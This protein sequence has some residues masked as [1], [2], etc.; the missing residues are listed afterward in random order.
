MIRLQV[1]HPVLIS[2][3]ECFSP[4]PSPSRRKVMGGGVA[5]VSRG[6][7]LG[8]Q[9]TRQSCEYVPYI[10][11]LLFFLHSQPNGAW[12]PC[13]RAP[14]HLPTQRAGGQ[15]DF[16]TG[17]ADGAPRSNRLNDFRGSDPP[18]PPHFQKSRLWPHG[19]TALG[20]VLQD[21]ADYWNSL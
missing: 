19:Q 20:R 12:S 13:S 7:G 17:A 1:L 6:G 10:V 14:A 8:V 21:H 4:P 5:N 11:C 2:S 15:P 9:A 18:S 3:P 16:N